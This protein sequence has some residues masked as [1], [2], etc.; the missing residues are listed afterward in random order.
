MTGLMLDK[1]RY[2]NREIRKLNN[3]QTKEIC[4]QSVTEKL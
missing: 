3:D 2:I 1:Y 4:S